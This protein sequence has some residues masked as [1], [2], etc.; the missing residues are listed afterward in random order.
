MVAPLASTIR[1]SLKSNI[2]GKPF[3]DTDARPSSTPRNG[4]SYADRSWVP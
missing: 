2:S 4:F 1:T 3:R